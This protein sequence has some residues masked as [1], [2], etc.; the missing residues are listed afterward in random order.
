MLLPP[1]TY[2]RKSVRHGVEQDPKTVN[3]VREIDVAPELANAVKRYIAS[4]DFTKSPYLFQTSLCVT[5]FI[6][7]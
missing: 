2:V 6:R 3:A 4:Q 7:F 1:I 5:A